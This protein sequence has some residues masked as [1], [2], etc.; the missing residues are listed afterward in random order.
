MGRK[1]EL[2]SPPND[3]FA[4]AQSLEGVAKGSVAGTINCATLENGETNDGEVTKSVWYSWTAPMDGLYGFSA[5]EIAAQPS[6]DLQ[7]VVYTGDALGNLN[8]VPSRQNGVS[9]EAS[10]R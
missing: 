8:L 10:T 2:L 7:A 4:A 6:D 9:T 3:N 1:S 5:L